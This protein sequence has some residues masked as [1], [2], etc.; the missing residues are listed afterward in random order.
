MAAALVLMFAPRF[1][2]T[3]GTNPYLLAA[4]FV[5]ALY[6]SV[7]IHEIGHL[8]VARRYRMVVA[9]ITLHLLG[10]ETAIEGESRTPAQEFWTTV[11]GPMT[12]LA[13]GLLAWLIGRGLEPGEAHSVW[14]AI[15]AVNVL[16]AVFNLVPAF[17]LD[18]G[19]VFRALVWAV[20][21]REAVG[22]KAA[23]WSGR[24]FAVVALV[25]PA[26]WLVFGNDAITPVDVAVGAI[27]AWFLWSGASEALRVADRSAR[28][29]ALYARALAEAGV[30]PP[31]DAPT[32]P[33]D[34]NG[35]PLLRAMSQNPAEI[36]RL[37]EADGTTF[38]QLR[39]ERVDDAYREGT[40]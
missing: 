10:G 31:A 6:V 37:T 27:I 17:P 29:N 34:L 36:Y 2:S 30:E 28:L 33:A 3:S 8:V 13:I 11:V 35:I 12:S 21:G 4:L 16:V 15:A 19:R 9:S 22:T 7:L 5:F 18:G 24:V 1:R 23:A 14:M 20:T 25:V 40:Q 39:A 32:L 26:V 38:G